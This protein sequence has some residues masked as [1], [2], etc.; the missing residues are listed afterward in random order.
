MWNS[1]KFLFMGVNLEKAIFCLGGIFETYV[2]ICT[3]VYLSGSPQ[4]G[5]QASDDGDSGR[6]GRCSIYHHGVVTSL[7]SPDQNKAL[8]A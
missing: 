5:T 4:D 1:I 3:P 6:E 8:V 2:H 7:S